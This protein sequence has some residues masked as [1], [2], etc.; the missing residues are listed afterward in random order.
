M[1]ILMT[2]LMTQLLTQPKLKQAQRDLEN[3]L[4][5]LTD[6]TPGLVDLYLNSVGVGSSQR[7]HYPINNKVQI[8]FTER[9]Q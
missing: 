3:K 8:K 2:I 5:N 4:G 6:L 9:S 7:Q 1:T